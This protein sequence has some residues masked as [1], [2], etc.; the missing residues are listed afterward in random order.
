M[1]VKEVGIPNLHQPG[2][3]Q[4]WYYR[5]PCSGYAESLA[6]IHGLFGK[7]E[8]ARQSFMKAAIK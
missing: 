4:T 1:V 7:E 2:V 3:G 6:K 8:K 5:T